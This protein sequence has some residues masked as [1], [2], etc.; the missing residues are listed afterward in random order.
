[1]VDARTKVQRE[2]IALSCI[3]N[4]HASRESNPDRAYLDEQSWYTICPAPVEG[5][6]DYIASPASFANYSSPE[7]ES[8]LHLESIHSHKIVDTLA[9]AFSF[10][11]SSSFTTGSTLAL[12]KFIIGEAPPLEPPDNH[13]APRDNLDFGP[14]DS[15]CNLPVTNPRTV[16]HFGLTP[17]LW[18]TPR[19]I[20]FANNQRECSTHYA[21]FGQIIGKVAILESAP[22]TL[23]SVPVLCRKGFE[24]SF[25][26]P[27]SVGI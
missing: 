26:I 1:M 22:D 3:A 17:Q 18:P 2:S 20:K 25:K 15:G 11:A 9:R 8:Y 24:V 7:N 21:D 14:A 23:I 16:K 6:S 5:D 10:A 13:V 27:G 4:S 19:W 12:E